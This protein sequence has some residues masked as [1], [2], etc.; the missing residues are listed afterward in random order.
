MRL[1]RTFLALILFG[2]AFGY[3]EAAVVVYLRT[4]FVPIRQKTFRTVAPNDLFPLL[5]AE[6]LRAAGPEYVGL[7]AIELGREVATIVMLAAAG[8]AIAGNFRQ[9]LAG[10]MIAFGVWDIFYYVFLRLLIGWP[11]S[12][13]T[14]DLLFLVPVPWVG[15]VIA[16]VIVSL[17]M[18]LAG[19]AILWYEAAGQP[20]RFRRLDWVLVFVGGL[21]VIVAFC[22]DWRQLTAGGWPG[23]FNWPVY[24]MGEAI[25][26][27]GFLHALSSRPRNAKNGQSCKT[28]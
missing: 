21:T 18:I 14:L 22:W 9:W 27:A 24:A 1:K 8:L 15:P 10:F 26:A 25:G 13:M 28:R 3:V 12:L 7:L 11:E 4:I 16:P 5:T 6:H 2:I 19:W 20:L 17:S 23:S